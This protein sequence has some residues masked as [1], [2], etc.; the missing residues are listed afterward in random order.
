MRV[1]DMLFSHAP[2]IARRK[3]RHGWVELGKRVNYGRRPYDHDWD[4]LIILDACRWDLWQE[5]AAKHTVTTMFQSEEPVY[6][7]GSSSDEWLLKTFDEV[8]NEETAET[9][10]VTANPYTHLLNLNRF[11]HVE[12]VWKYARDPKSGTVFPEAVTN[13]A[14]RAYR[15]NPQKRHVIHYFQ[16]H[17]P[18]LHCLDRYVS[19]VDN[20]AVWDG[21]ETGKF[22]RQEV[23]KDYGQNLQTVLD[24]VEKII[25]DVN[26]TVAVT[27]DH[28]NLIG[29][30]GLY[31][32]PSWVPLP[33]LKRVPWAVAEGDG[34]NEY[35]LKKKDEIRTIETKEP[36]IKE[37]LRQLGYME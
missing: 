37:H 18:F 22:D 21:V 5:Y 13:E 6:S 25:N 19:G 27:S 10:Y 28:G 15:E 33:A 11:H 20:Q 14:I 12:E 35:K 3:W 24:D 8:D 26:G 31:G 2:E 17:A 1:L 36:S 30:W 34:A 29:E 7:C 32:H 16:P 9:V 4:I 23:F